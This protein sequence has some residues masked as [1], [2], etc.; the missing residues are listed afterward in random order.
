MGEVRGANAG[1]RDVAADVAAMWDVLAGGGLVI[2][3]AAGGYTI[4]GPGTAEGGAAINSAKG[5]PSHKRLGL[6][7][8]N[9]G[10]REVHVLADDKREIIDCITKDYNLPLHVIASFHADHPLIAQLDEAALKLCTA[11]GTITSGVN[12]GGFF[13]NAV[14]VRADEGTLFPVFAS[15]C[16]ASGAAPKARVD[17]IEPEVLAAADLVI[18]YGP[19]DGW[20]RTTSTQ[21][22]FDTMQLVRWG[23]A[24]DS[25]SWVMKHH[26]GIELPADPG[27]G[28]SPGGHVDEFAL[29]GVE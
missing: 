29:V 10:E 12:M 25:I 9:R 21:F 5:R 18:D 4:A 20:S 2:C 26:F 23:R 7:M 27:R 1:R 3:P 6:M 11:N 24:F 22:N 14:N 13:L 28:V 16:N 8:G 15:S 19:Q 17:D